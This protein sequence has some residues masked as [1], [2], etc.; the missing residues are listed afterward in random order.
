MRRDALSPVGSWRGRSPTRH[1]YRDAIKR[2]CVAAAGLALVTGC[3]DTRVPASHRA[4]TAPSR[5]I[6]VATTAAPQPRPSRSRAASRQGQEKPGY[7]GARTVKG[8]HLVGLPLV[9]TDNITDASGSHAYAVYFRLSRPL[10]GYLPYP[11][12]RFSPVVSIDG[13][14]GQTPLYHYPGTTLP[15]YVAPTSGGASHY[16]AL[17]DAVLR[18]GPGRVVRF[19]LIL[20]DSGEPRLQANVRTTR[21]QPPDVSHRYL[22]WI[23]QPYGRLLGCRSR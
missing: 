18:A 10:P 5:G 1:C 6:P 23:D 3:G 12:N 22:D 7:V 19:A 14:I 2:S 16:G 4:V 20:G 9:A 11:T 17:D 13:G 8:V 15:C 21:L